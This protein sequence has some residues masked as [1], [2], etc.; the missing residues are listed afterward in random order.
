M[1][2]KEYI[3]ERPDVRR[4]KKHQQ[5]LILRYLF[6]L[7]PEEIAEAILKVKELTNKKIEDEN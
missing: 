6:S 2:K 3:R 5:L 4:S 7:E 1:S